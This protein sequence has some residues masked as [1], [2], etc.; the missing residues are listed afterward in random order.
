MQ[1]AHSPPHLLSSLFFASGVAA[2]VY[3]VAWQR[4]LFAAF[5][6]DLESVTIVVAA[7]M[8]G[9]G[10]GALLG[11]W[12]AD[13]WPKRRLTLFALSEAGIGLFGLCS[14]ALLF[15][16]GERFALWPLAGIAMVNFLLVLIPTLLMGA[17]LPILIAY[18]AQIWRHVGSATG[19]LYAINTLGAAMG[20][21]IAG[22]WLFRH[23]T[24]NEAIWVAAC[25]NLCA[26]VLAFWRLRERVQS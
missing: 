21:L 10:L 8:L 1:N 7:F 4:I 22:F 25:I 26:A 16:A 6:A 18:V 13:L 3:Q 5:G 12:A 11:G 24:L 20:S 19:H 15:W 14:P 17:T 23:L 9:L 2:L